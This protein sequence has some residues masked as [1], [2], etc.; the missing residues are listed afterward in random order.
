MEL[1]TY[2]YVTQIEFVNAERTRAHARVT[3][4]YSGGTVVLEKIDG[5]WRAIEL[6]NEWIT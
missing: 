2:P 5:Q 3:I 4:G 1:E 6:A